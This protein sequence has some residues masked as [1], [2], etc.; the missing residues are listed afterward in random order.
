MNTETS[1]D[2]IVI[3]GGQAGLSVSYH[4]REL[5][6]EHVVLDASP[7]IGD[8]WRNRWDSLHLFTPA[9]YDGLDGM[10]FPGDPG[11]WP[12]KDAM[13]D[14][15]E[16]YARTFELPVRSGMR[17]DELTRGP[18]G[19]GFIARC[20]DETFAAR[21][22]V[23]AM[24]NYQVPRIPA[25]AAELSPAIRQLDA[26][27]YR[28]PDQLLPGRVLLVG[29]GNSAAEI[30]KEL[31]S[32]HQVMVA[33]PNT[34]EVPGSF[35]S[36][37]SRH[38]VVHVLNRIVF[39]HVMS[40]NTPV[41][42]KARPKVMSTGVP[43]IRVK[44]KDLARLG[45]Q[46]AGRVTGVVDGKPVLDDGTVAEVENIVWCTG[47]TPGLDWLRMPILDERG[48]P[49]HERGVVSDVPGLYFVG[50]H[51][52]TSMSSAMVHGVGRDAAR[53][54]SLVRDRAAEPAHDD[55]PLQPSEGPAVSAGL[56]ASA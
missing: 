4:L 40:V 6:V 5:G 7:R 25:F 14:Y 45:V 26:G 42:R 44:S 34:G 1:V 43:L 39:T 21:T 41:G 16:T 3:G 17:V 12:S 27:E 53:I 30:A 37:V 11:A 8:A 9:R 13:A 38:V 24:S 33:G 15:L 46:R 56:K 20:G 19:A 50:L 22:V 28:S 18:D 31:A 10:R 51:F 47:F 2:T 32:G 29:A 49:R 54:A 23:V 36:F 35:T 55:G 48:E 52:L